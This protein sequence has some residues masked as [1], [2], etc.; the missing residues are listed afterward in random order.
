M[1]CVISGSN[2]GGH[3]L[4]GITIQLKS[5]APDTGLHLQSPGFHIPPKRPERVLGFMQV[6]RWVSQACDSRPGAGTGARTVACSEET[7]PLLD[8]GQPEESR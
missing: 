5:R 7:S 2:P 8:W 6:L 3:T 4:N 1:T